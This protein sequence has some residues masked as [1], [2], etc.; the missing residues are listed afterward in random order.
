MPTRL[1][2]LKFYPSYCTGPADLEAEIGWLLALHNDT[3]LCVQVPLPAADGSIVQS[4][5]LG[6]ESRLCVLYS[7]VPGR[8]FD[9]GLKPVKLRAVGRLMGDL[10]AHGKGFEGRF[11]IPAQQ[12]SFY[13]DLDTWLPSVTNHQAL[14]A[15]SRDTLQHAVRVVQRDLRNKP[16]DPATYGLV[17]GDLHQWNIVFSG[18]NARAIDFADCGWGFFAYDMA[19]TLMYLRHP[20]VGNTDHTHQYPELEAAFLDGYSDVTNLP[21]NLGTELDFFVAARL[22]VMLDWL[23]N[24]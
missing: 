24:D 1:A 9:R 19:T 16:Q 4:L 6:D 13:L 23:L 21:P 3:G 14:T 8:F 17:H 20:W 18:A 2:T 12:Q 22:L 11:R 5:S 10:H 15:G 7:W